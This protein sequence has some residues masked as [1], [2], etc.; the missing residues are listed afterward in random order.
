MHSQ[1]QF[2]LFFLGDSATLPASSIRGSRDDPYRV[3]THEPE[4]GGRTLGSGSQALPSAWPFATDAGH[5]PIGPPFPNIPLKS[6]VANTI[7]EGL[8]IEPQ[9]ESRE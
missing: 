2:L 5:Q 4:L 9:R 1:R 7:E 6:G 3:S 8:Q